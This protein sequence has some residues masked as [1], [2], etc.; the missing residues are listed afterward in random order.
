[1]ADA[2]AARPY[3]L[4]DLGIGIATAFVKNACL[5]LVLPAALASAEARSS[6]ASG[7]SF[8]LMSGLI[9][10]AFPLGMT[11]STSVLIFVPSRLLDSRTPFL[12]CVAGALHILTTHTVCHCTRRPRPCALLTVA[13]APCAALCA[14]QV[15]RPA[16]PRRGPPHR[17]RAL[18]VAALRPP[19]YP[20]HHGPRLR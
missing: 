5:T 13:R 1:M 18:H 12:L 20:H 6:D 2:V 10:A 16:P 3:A 11:F 8:L 9:A 4:F 17:V 7:E 14:L 19:R 15:R